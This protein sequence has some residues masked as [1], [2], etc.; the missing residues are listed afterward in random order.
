CVPDDA[1]LDTALRFA[2]RAAGRD[3][4]LV[5]RTKDSLRASGAVADPKSAVE[6]EF[7]AQEWSVSRPGYVEHLVA[8]RDRLRQA[9]E[10]AKAQAAKAREAGRA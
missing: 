6:I 9:R 2:R 8:L 7:A 1:L 5:R 10:R 4:E 3:G